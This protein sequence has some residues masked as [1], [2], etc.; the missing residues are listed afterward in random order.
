LG[1]LK[2]IPPGPDRTSI[3]FSKGITIPKTGGLFDLSNDINEQKNIAT[4]NTKKVVK[5]SSLIQKIK[6]HPDK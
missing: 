6:N 4:N 5:M 1:Q 2:Y 3:I